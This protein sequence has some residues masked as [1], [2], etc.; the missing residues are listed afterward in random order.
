MAY[1]LTEKG[2]DVTLIEKNSRVGGLARTCYYAGHPYEFGPHIWFWPGGKDAPI[3]DTIVRLTNDEL[4]YIERRLF[5][6]VESDRRKY[7]YPV[8]YADVAAMPERELIDRELRE[9]RDEHLKLIEERL[10]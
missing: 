6:Y 8:H 9:N 4:Y 2:Y 1:Y 3:N 10:P 5:T 7:R